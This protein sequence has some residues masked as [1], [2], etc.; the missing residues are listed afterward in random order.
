[1]IHETNWGC[2]CIPYIPISYGYACSHETCE[3]QCINCDANGLT[4]QLILTYRPGNL[5]VSKNNQ[6]LKCIESFCSSNNHTII[7]GDLNLPLIKLTNS[8]IPVS[9]I[10]SAEG[11]FLRLCEENCLH[12]YVFKPTR[13]SNTLDL[14]LWN[15]KN[16]I[17]NC[18]IFEPFS[19][20]DHSSV[21][22]EICGFT[23]KQVGRNYHHNFRKGDYENLSIY[24][25]H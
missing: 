2:G 12:Q 8:E 18:S 6:Y 14:V 16:L 22:F 15:N 4:F 11:N 23:L 21:Y 10:N 5:S 1:M 24:L 20:S 13:G 25:S 19:Q 3:I 17:K 9:G 7:L